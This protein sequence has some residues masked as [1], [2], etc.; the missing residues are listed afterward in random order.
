MLQTKRQIQVVWRQYRVLTPTQEICNR[1]TTASETAE[2]QCEENN[3][4]QK[5]QRNDERLSHGYNYS[6][7]AEDTTRL[8]ALFSPRPAAGS[9]SHARFDS[10]TP[11]LLSSP[12]HLPKWMAG[13]LSASPDWAAIGSICFR[14]AVKIALQ[15]RSIAAMNGVVTHHKRPWS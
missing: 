4:R 13:F 1:A 15:G 10:F 9:R 2:W 8:K 12:S 6:R 5:R 3:Q 11:L 7:F 14:V